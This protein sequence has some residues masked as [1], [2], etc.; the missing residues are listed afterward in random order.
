MRRTV[1]GGG[2][3]SQSSPNVT[4]VSDICGFFKSSP[5]ADDPDLLEVLS[6]CEATTDEDEDEDEEEEEPSLNDV[7]LHEDRK[8]LDCSFGTDSSCSNKSSH[9]DD[10]M[11]V[12]LRHHN[13]ANARS[14][15]SAAQRQRHV[16]ISPKTSA[17]YEHFGSYE[18]G[19]SAAERRPFGIQIS[20][21]A[22]ANIGELPSPSS[23]SL[24]SG[25]GQMIQKQLTTK[26]NSAPI[27][28]KKEKK[29][30]DDFA[31]QKIVSV[32]QIY[33]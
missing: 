32:L 22:F 31:A 28:L 2:A 19:L 5:S 11:E 21:E 16:T 30:R 24:H 8:L 29:L 4:T 3:N 23:A 26:S 1:V 12:V 25:H 20:G 9:D 33:K 13:T 18:L 27:L 14:F 15:V 17:Q 7:K 6:L 10:E